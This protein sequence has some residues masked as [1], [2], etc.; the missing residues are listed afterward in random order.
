MANK[1]TLLLLFGFFCQIMLTAQPSFRNSTR[2]YK[3]DIKTRSLMPGGM[4]DLDGDLVDDLILLD[5]GKDLMAFK[6]S[7]KNFSLARIDS[8]RV[9]K[10][11]QW[12]L[13]IGDLNNDGL[14]E[15]ITAGEYA[16]IDISTLKNNLFET[17]SQQGGFFAQGSNTID[18]NNDGWLDYFVCDDDAPPKIYMNDKSGKLV[19]KNIINFSN[20]D[21]T[22]GSGNYGSEWVDVNGDLLPDL[23]IAK[24]R[25]GVESPL[26]KRRINRLYINKGNSAFEEKGAEFNLNSGQQTWVTT[27]GDI[28]NDGDQDAFVVNHYAPHALMENIG[29]S[30]FVE[31]PLDAPV[32]A[33]TFQAVMRD[34]DNDGFLDILLVGAEGSKLLHNRG[35]KSFTL[36]EKIIGPS[37]PRSMSVGDINDDGFLD[38]HAHIC[39]PINLIGIKDDELWL[40]N[41]NQ[42][43]YI[44][45]SL[46]GTT[47]NKSGIGAQVEIYGQW[48]RQVRYVKG[49][50]SYGIF[51]SMQQHFGLGNG[52]NV[53]SIIIRWPSGI[54]DKYRNLAADQTYYAQ[55]G[56]CLTS[57]IVLYPDVQLFNNAPIQLSA[58]AGMSDYKWNTGLITKNISIQTE[59]TYHVRMIDGNGCITVSKPIVVKSACFSPNLKL[60]NEAL[61]VKL[62]KGEELELSSISAATYKWSNGSTDRTT[63]ASVTGF[64]G[65]TATD[66]CGNTMSDQIFVDV[67]ETN[68]LVIN[69]TIKQGETATLVTN[70]KSS[71]WFTSPDETIPFYVGDSL[72]TEPLDTT[73]KYYVQIRKLIDEKT[74]HVGEVL[75]PVSNLYGSNSTEGY[76]VFNVSAKCTIRSVKVNT[77]TEGLRK[78]I[79]R[80]DKGKV[81]YQ[82]E[83]YLNIGIQTIQLDAQMVPGFSYE[84]ATDKTVNVQ[85]FGYISPR[86]VRTFN[87]TSYPYV[88]DDIISIES[89]SFGAIYYYYF[90]DWDIAYEM[91]TCD[92]DKKEVTVLVEEGSATGE[93]MDHGNISIFPNPTNTTIEIKTSD[94]IN[95]KNIVIRDIQG[96]VL[97][98]FKKDDTQIDISPFPSGMYIIQIKSNLGWRNFK[99]IKQ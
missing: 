11:D 63:T 49:G 74:K 40:N 35:D 55:E 95:I 52:T 96:R 3:K 50:E 68:L 28:D 81:I 56:K 70:D 1:T 76:L 89:S 8:T 17:V 26:D 2:L 58:S 30:H 85:S 72:I 69:D 99:L 36:I 71:N 6:S 39:E 43:H 77:D 91:V 19:L 18:I 44:K 75:F 98:I 41:T 25:A 97:S 12:T 27:F 7:G 29:G 53:D 51:N 82:K 80:D 33:F 94:I 86:L 16:Q 10:N 37:T 90:Y 59:G 21:Q 79:I 20:N 47:S 22:D 4:T 84:L 93:V 73:T 42:N 13:T 62:C 24:C 60:I 64:I 23:C 67:L 54:L 48:G 15:I 87:G 83:F 92:S 34:F 78:I 38:I 31:I 5:R 66:Y 14:N 65:L 61:S 88:V 9:S 32:S 45:I 46:D 57:A